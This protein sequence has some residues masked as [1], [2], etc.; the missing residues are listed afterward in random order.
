LAALLAELQ[1]APSR[2]EA[3][4]LIRQGAVEIDGSRVDDVRAEVDLAAP[5]EFLLRAGKRKFVCV[6]VE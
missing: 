2:S 6:E 4:R 3:E 5:R 1:L